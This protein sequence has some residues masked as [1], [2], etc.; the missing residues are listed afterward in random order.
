MSTLPLEALAAWLAGA[1][2]QST[3]SAWFEHAP[4]AIVE[5]DAED[6]ADALGEGRARDSGT[7]SALLMGRSTRD[8]HRLYV[9][10]AR[11]DRPSTIS[12]RSIS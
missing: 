9:L 6:R 4:G 3:D 2:P 8:A 11:S 5:V 12:Y 10:S 1:E 7:T